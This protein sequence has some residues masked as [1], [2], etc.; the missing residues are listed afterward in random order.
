MFGRYTISTGKLIRITEYTELTTATTRSLAYIAPLSTVSG[1]LSLYKKSD[2]VVMGTTSTVNGLYADLGNGYFLDDNS[3][4][5]NNEAIA[6]VKPG[7]YRFNAH[8]MILNNATARFV[9]CFL[10]LPI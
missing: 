7:F 2:T 6:I 10:F 9:I 5:V 4:L 8:I 1:G 3:T